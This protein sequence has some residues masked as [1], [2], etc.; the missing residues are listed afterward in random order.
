MA[1]VTFALDIGFSLRESASGIFARSGMGLY[2]PVKY[3]IGTSSTFIYSIGH[4]NVVL[5]CVG[6]VVGEWERQFMYLDKT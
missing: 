1:R 3:R 6:I 2:A 5:G 4:N